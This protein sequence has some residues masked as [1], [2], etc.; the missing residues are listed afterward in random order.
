M[1]AQPVGGFTGEFK[2]TEQGEVRVTATFDAERKR[3]V[4]SVRDTGIGIAPQDHARIFEEFSQVETRIQKRVKGTGLGLPLSKSLA[5][6]LGGELT[7]ESVLGQGSV[8]T[9]SIPPE[10]GDSSRAQRSEAPCGRPVSNR[11]RREHAAREG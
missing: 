9:L 8:F 11:W 7:L 5:E 1:V 4:L 3:L 2:I 10:R 6:L